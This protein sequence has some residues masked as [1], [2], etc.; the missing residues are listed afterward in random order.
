MLNLNS[1][2]GTKSVLKCDFDHSIIESK[3]NFVEGTSTELD[4]IAK[5]MLANYAP[6]T[7]V[8]VLMD[9]DRETR[10]LQNMDRVTFSF[11]RAELERLTNERYPEAQ[12]ELLEGRYISLTLSIQDMLNID[13]RSPE[14]DKKRVMRIAMK[15]VKPVRK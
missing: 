11:V 6:E 3:Y 14:G 8:Q 10:T 5:M 7:M 9:M 13:A 4:N 1:G 12:I 15:I 2:L